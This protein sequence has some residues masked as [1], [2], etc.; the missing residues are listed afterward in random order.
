MSG[1]LIS[2]NTSGASALVSAPSAVIALVG[3]APIGAVNTLTLVQSPTADSVF[4]LEASGFSIPKALKAIRA[5]EPNAKIMV[6]N[7]AAADA[8]TAQTLVSVVDESITLVAGA[9]QLAYAPE[10][11]PAPVVKDTTL[12]TTYVQGTDYTISSTG[13]FAR[14][15]VAIGATDVVKISYSHLPNHTFAAD[16]ATL[17]DPPFR[18]LTPVVYNKTKSTTYTVGTDYT[19]D[20]YGV[21]RRVVGG[22]MT[23]A[24]EFIISYEV[25]DGATA[26][27]I[28]G[29]ASPRT[30]LYCFQT[31]QSV[32]GYEPTL[33]ICPELM[34]LSGVLSAFRSWV[35]N[36]YG[37]QILLDAPSGLTVATLE[38]ARGAGSGNI[39]DV[40][41]PRVIVCFPHAYVYDI[42]T[43]ANE[44]RP[45]SPFIAGFIAKVD[46][47]ESPGR[48]IGN[49]PE[50]VLGIESLEIA[51]TF[52]PDGSRT[53]D[54]SR[55]NDVD[56]VTLRPGLFVWGDRAS[57]YRDDTG[58]KNKFN[59]RRVADILKRSL[60]VGSNQYIGRNITRVLIDTILQNGQA[61]MDTLKQK[62]WILDGKMVYNSVDNPPSELALGRLTIG[63]QYTPLVSLDTLIYVFTITTE[64]IVEL[65]GF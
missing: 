47:L 55:V 9:G 16:K 30:G 65:L 33:W 59:V 2:E 17:A 12:A 36:T 24:Q 28:I 64:D 54:C 35:T 43:D 5:Q 31:A 49:Y 10:S 8:G 27:D 6:V 60:V 4:G 52:D 40:S 48:T 62:G 51:L 57:S 63:F 41:D 61:Y 14:V 11:S 21:V 18:S 50:A 1:V 19:I 7:V 39:V 29:A 32:Y 45:L 23:A 38:T 13:A 15:G 25:Y 34:G 22:T 46:R 56:C 3:T 42:S 58:V 37:G 20:Q 26:A 44:L 53:T